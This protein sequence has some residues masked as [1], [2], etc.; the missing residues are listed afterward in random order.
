M[1]LNFTLYSNKSQMTLTINYDKNCN[2]QEPFTYVCDFL[3]LFNSK[4]KIINSSANIELICRQVLTDEMLKK[5][6]LFIESYKDININVYKIRDFL[7]KLNL[8]D[9][10]FI[11]PCHINDLSDYN[12]CLIDVEIEALNNQLDIP[13]AIS[14]FEK[15]SKAFLETYDIHGR[16]SKSKFTVGELDKSKR[17]C[18]FCKK[19][20]KETSFKKRAHAISEAL[21][22]KHLLLGEECDDCN[23]L[24]SRTLEKD[25]LLT[26]RLFNTFY[27]IKNKEGK[28]P[29]INQKN[30]LQVL[31]S[32]KH[33]NFNN[34]H[35]LT[36]PS[37][38]NLIII[39]SQNDSDF[40]NT[41]TIHL[42]S[43]E[44][45]IPKNIY[46]CLVKFALSVIET[47]LIPKF[48]STASWLINT[49]SFN[50][51]LPKLCT[52]LT[53]FNIVR[54]P[55]MLVYIRKNNDLSLPYA[56]GEFHYACFKYVFIIPIDSKEE[57][58]YS[59]AENFEK[60]KSFFKH[61][62]FEK[63]DWLFQDYNEDIS[64]EY[65]LN[66]KFEPTNS[67]IKS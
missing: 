46:K 56:V 57:L 39:N 20:S 41:K 64:K 30:R 61:C 29:E 14:E 32:N 1:E 40:K 10:F 49:G 13:E 6:D 33:L 65:T 38:N 62:K 47:D 51:Y 55:L 52:L 24:F 11:L 27:G 36:A 34:L 4:P 50:P 45:Y 23:Q 53:P 54:K 37:Q 67:G 48:D 66:I 5:L 44:T 28:I 60:F 43:D 58:D 59:Q 17:V 19:D 35:G 16:S 15:I 3:D 7:N 25:F 21:G 31:N 42:K 22:N 12:K 26:V 8:G 63:R 9:F 2:S 18:R